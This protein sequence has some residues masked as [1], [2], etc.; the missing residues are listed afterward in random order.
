MAQVVEDE[1]HVGDHQRHVGQP[2]RVGVGLA[3]RL[4]R[5][6]QVVAEEADRAAG[7][8]RQVLDRGEPEAGEALGDRGVGVR[9][10]A[11]LPPCLA[12]DPVAPA[13]H[14]ARADADEGVAADLA[15]LGRLEQEAGRPLG[16]AGAQLEEGRDGRLAVVDEA[17][18]DGD[19][20]ALGGELPGLVEARLDPQLGGVSRDGH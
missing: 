3:E 13:Q 20:V 18:A 4:D 17:C 16:L 2:E 15:L 7:E 1:Q 8:R 6:H 14:R 5:A 10:L 9:R 19:D 11:V 12:E